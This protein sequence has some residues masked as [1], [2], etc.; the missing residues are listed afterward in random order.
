MTCW[1]RGATSAQAVFISRQMHDLKSACCIY[2]TVTDHEVF[3]Y[4]CSDV[5]IHTP[6]SLTCKANE[7]MDKFKLTAHRLVGFPEC[8]FASSC[9]FS[10]RLV[11]H[12]SKPKTAAAPSMRPETKARSSPLPS[13]A[14]A[15]LVLISSP[16]V[17]LLRLSLRKREGEGSQGQTPVLSGGEKEP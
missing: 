3:I 5:Y 13:P 14:A 7:R 1:F 9:L 15:T 10:S 16:P 12:T 4:S 17:T 8:Q 6:V 11:S 2:E